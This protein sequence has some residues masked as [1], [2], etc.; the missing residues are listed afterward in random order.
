MSE[1]LR[2][3]TRS[4]YTLD[5][6]AR[7]VPPEAWDNPSCC[8]GWTARDV[9]DHAIGVVGYMGSLAG[10]DAPQ[11]LGEPQERAAAAI[12][13]TLDALDH[14]G[15]LH[16]EVSTFM[17]DQ[18]IDRLLGVMYVDAMVHAWDVADAAGIEHGID[19]ALAEVALASL[20]GRGDALRSPGRYGAE[21][22]AEGPGA[23]DRLIAFSGRRPVAR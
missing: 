10:G 2:R 4:L 8:E 3:Y 14:H 5:A 18:T 6:V 20:A 9:L 7:R 16:R 12:E 17:G 23:V 11:V 13:A 1:N 19:A 22:D 21:V 15:V